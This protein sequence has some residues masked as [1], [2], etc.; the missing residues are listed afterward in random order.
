MTNIE[1][2]GGIA[3][4]IFR[5]TR[6]EEALTAALQKYRERRA[7]IETEQVLAKAARPDVARVDQLLPGIEL[8]P[9]RRD[10]IARL[11]HDIDLMLHRS[12]ALNTALADFLE[13]MAAAAEY[14]PELKGWA[15]R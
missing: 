2:I 10:R 4:T 11:L 9:A 8:E 12:D 15:E 13:E 5:K 14:V 7:S 1:E 3:M 6:F